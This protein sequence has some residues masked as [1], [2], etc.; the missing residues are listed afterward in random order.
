MGRAVFTQASWC[1]LPG[2]FLSRY[3]FD[4]QNVSASLSPACLADNA[5]S[6]W[7]CILAPVAV[8]Y[9]Q[10]PLFAFNSRFDRWQ[11]ANVLDVPCIASQ[12]YTP[13]YLPCNCTKAEQVR[14]WHFPMPRRVPPP[15]A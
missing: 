11:L 1:A 15:P 6:P 14:A 12:P 8:A 3:V 7:R 10:A 4:M 5:G 9:V 2:L 13:P